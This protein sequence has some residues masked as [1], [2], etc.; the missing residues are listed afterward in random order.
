MPGINGIDFL[1]QV[2]QV[3]PETIRIMMTGHPLSVTKESLCDVVAAHRFLIKPVQ[4]DVFLEIIEANLQLYI[5][6]K[7]AKRSNPISTSIENLKSGMI[8]A[9]HIQNTSG[10]IIFPKNAELTEA[11]I[12]HLQTS[13][14]DYPTPIQVYP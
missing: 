10:E 3:S 5:H 1:K 9:E 2:V 11:R 6:G 7:S 4:V 8:L 13:P 14:E 12:E